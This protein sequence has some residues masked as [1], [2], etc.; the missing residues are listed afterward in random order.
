MSS[1]SPKTETH[2]VLD[3]ILGLVSEIRV[4]QTVMSGRIDGFARV[5]AAQSDTLV[6]VRTDAATL[7]A[8][9]R[10][11]RIG[12]DAFEPD[13]RSILSELADLRKDFADLRNDFTDLLKDFA[14][15]RKDVDKL[16]IGQSELR[17]Q[18]LQTRSQIMDRIDRQQAE[19][20]R[21]RDDIRVTW[22]TADAAIDRVKSLR[23]D[24]D[25][26]HGMIS[27]MERRYQTLA[28]MVDE[29]RNP[30]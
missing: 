27:A 26:L 6:A 24:V 13:L 10:S 15:L 1:D 21:M 3:R 9:V 2:L 17:A 19:L 11:I 23:Q 16:Q 20:E 18:I 30:R 7:Q 4:E 28:A 14:D 25:G 12:F 8:E 22:S 5:Q 29:L